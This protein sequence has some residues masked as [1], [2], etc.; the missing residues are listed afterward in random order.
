MAE[1]AEEG[2]FEP[3]ICIFRDFLVTLQRKNINFY[4]KN[5]RYMAKFTR[6]KTNFNG[7]LAVTN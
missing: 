7:K 3:N 2:I 5:Q 4:T 6:I 1:V